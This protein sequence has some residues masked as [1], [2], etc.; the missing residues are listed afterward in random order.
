[1]LVNNDFGTLSIWNF[2]KIILFTFKN[3]HQNA[4]EKFL[5]L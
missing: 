5:H 2:A 4:T 3:R 1:M